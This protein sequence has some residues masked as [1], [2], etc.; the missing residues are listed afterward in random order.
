M[1]HYAGNSYSFT[2]TSTPDKPWRQQKFPS[3]KPTDACAIV[4]Y[5][6][7]WPSEQPWQQ[8]PDFLRDQLY[9]FYSP[10]MTILPGASFGVFNHDE[11]YV[12]LD[13][14]EQNIRSH[15]QPLTKPS[16]SFNDSSKRS[17]PVF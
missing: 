4:T 17:E 2:N 15:W 6:H 8:L 13:A 5:P 3:E 9:R 7:Y 10:P 11:K 16:R 14:W 12:T 1:T